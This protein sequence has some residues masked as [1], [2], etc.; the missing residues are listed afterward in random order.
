MLNLIYF[1]HIE[2]IFTAFVN[3]KLKQKLLFVFQLLH[4]VYFLVI[5]KCLSTSFLLPFE[6]QIMFFAV[7]DEYHMCVTT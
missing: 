5:A 7:L 3:Y 4:I 2:M 1:S 6:E